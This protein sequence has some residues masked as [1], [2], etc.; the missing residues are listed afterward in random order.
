MSTDAPEDP[1]SEKPALGALFLTVVIDL[2]G[3]GIVLPLLPL[4]ADD[5]GAAP[6]LIGLLFAS[7]SATQFLT[8]PLWGRWSDRVGRRPVILLGLVGSALSY[9]LFAMSTRLPQPMLWLFVSRIA[10][11]VFGGTI[12]TAYAYIADVTDVSNRGRG[13]ALIGMAFGVG[14]TIGPALGGLGH[15]IDPIA[16]GLLATAF[17]LIALYV[18]W[19]R[20]KEPVRHRPHGRRTWLDLSSVQRALGT[21]S[22]PAL[23]LTIAVAVTCFALMESTLGLLGRRVYEFSI[24]EIGWLFTYLGFWIAFTQG[25]LVR[26]FLPRVGERRMAIGGA[27]LLALGLLLFSVD[28]SVLYLAC[29]AP[30]SVLGFGMIVPSVNAMISLRTDP[31]TQGEIMGLSQSL[32]SL[33]RIIGPVAGLSLFGIRWPLPFYAGA[34]G[35]VIALGLLL[36]RGRAAAS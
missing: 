21:R 5:Y 6:A 31:T 10:A 19:K 13:M 30:V 36:T 11:G 8:A 2:L 22:V 33:A 16:P 25:F 24:T 29:V 35:M 4:Y 1:S 20:L 9:F 32:Q 14:F 26:R 18:A 28:A 27:I 7:F 3:F 17:S 23:L 34:A 15:A 12:S